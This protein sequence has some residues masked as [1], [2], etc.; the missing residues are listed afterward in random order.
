MPWRVTRCGGRTLLIGGGPRC[1]LYQ[2]EVIAKP[3]EALGIGMLPEEAFGSTPYHTDWLDT[4]ES[5]ALLRYQRHGFDDYVAHM[6]DAVGWRRH[7]IRLIGPLAR[8]WMVRGSPYY[9][10]AR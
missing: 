5:Q 1:Q 2:R 3:L 7:P 8:W 4:T 10:R 9:R 6:L